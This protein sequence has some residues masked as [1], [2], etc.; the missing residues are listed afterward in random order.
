MAGLISHL[1]KDERLELLADLNYLNMG[2]IKS[3][4]KKH[5]IPYAIAVEMRDGKRRPSGEYDR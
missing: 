1:N 2:E 4:C 3:F 5:G